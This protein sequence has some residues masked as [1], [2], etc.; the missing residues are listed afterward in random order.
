M[1]D[2]PQIVFVHG[3]FSSAAI[4]D[5][6]VSLLRNDTAFKDIDCL[7]F[8]YST[9]KFRLL[10]TRK[11]PSFDDLADR[12]RTFI[13]LNCDPAKPLL[14]V[15]HSQGGLI[16]QRFLARSLD[17]ELLES[18]RRI[19]MVVMFSCPNAGS[20]ILLSLRRVTVMWRHAQEKELRPLNDLVTATRRTILWKVIHAQPNDPKSCHIPIFLYAGDTDNVV[21][22]V[23]AFDVFPLENTAVIKGDH[24]SVIQPTG[25]EDES[26]KALSRRIKQ[27]IENTG[28]STRSAE[29]ADNGTQSEP[30]Q[31]S[32]PNV[33]ELLRRAR[34]YE[35]EGLNSRAEATYRRASSTR[36]LN[37]L[38]DYSRFQRRQG[39]LAGSIHTSSRIIEVLV[40]SDDTEENRVHQSRVM[41]TTGIAQ[42]NLGNLRQ[43]EKS[44]REAIR[45]VRGDTELEIEARAYALDNLGITLV[46]SADTKAARRCFDDALDIRERLNGKIGLAHTLMNIAR[47][48]MRDGNLEDAMSGCQRAMSLLDAQTDSAAMASALSIRGEVAYINS[49]FDAAQ[50]D[51]AKAL[52]LNE[53]TGR[54]VNIALSQQQLARVL[55]EQGDKV[56]AEIYARKALDHYRS[57][58]NAE[59][60]VGSNQTLAR[61]TYSNG[62]HELSITMLE[63]CV[64][65]YNDLGNLTGEAWSTLYLADVLFKLDRPAA[66]KARLERAAVLAATI[67]NAS[68]RRAVDKLIQL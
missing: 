6:F 23:S 30:L 56:Q 21:T 61:I 66:A 35:A 54:G 11:I 67:D 53:A 12:L 10:P 16:V 40:D 68:L 17:S 29:P 15:S 48:D 31:D 5:K 25:T 58:S 55:L 7:R 51:F 46:R 8:E 2:R 44:L 59:G 3:L 43:S 65:A 50:R 1:V 39:D 20:D 37:A 9:P 62:D 27:V 42:R 24:S 52:R 45:A 41:A 64:A 49:R 14:I 4:W 22:S 13:D 33:E 32:E 47:L 18:V 34:Q 60:E 28:E 38:Q 26:Y 57:S 63:D 19:K 36:N